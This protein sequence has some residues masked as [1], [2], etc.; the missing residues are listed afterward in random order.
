[1]PWVGFERKI[2]MFERVKIFHALGR[3]AIVV[4][5]TFITSVKLCGDILDRHVHLF[6]TLRTNIM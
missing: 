2:A 5:L 6:H 1:M 3:A 4:G